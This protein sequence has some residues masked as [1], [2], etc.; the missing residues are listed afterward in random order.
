[1]S[2]NTVA[3]YGRDLAH[4]STWLGKRRLASLTVSE[5]AEYPAWLAQRGLAPATVARHVVSLKVFCKFLQLEGLL[6]ENQASLL[7]SQKLWQKIPTVLSPSEIDRL[8]SAPPAGEPRWRR[9]R[10]ILELLYATGCRVSELSSMKLI[11]LQ[12]SERRCRCHGKGDKQRIVPLGER[13][14]AALERYPRPRATETG[15]TA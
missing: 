13:A 2:A 7:G 4:L 15:R 10:A 3:A 8:L 9:D 14:V 1:M 12:L 11:D 5:L 6:N